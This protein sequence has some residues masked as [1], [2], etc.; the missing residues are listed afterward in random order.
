MEMA[1]VYYS[2]LPFELICSQEV[3][4]LHYQRAVLL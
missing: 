2:V 3:Y 1:L 4:L